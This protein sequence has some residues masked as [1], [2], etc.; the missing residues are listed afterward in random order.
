MFHC[1]FLQPLPL[2]PVPGIDPYGDHFGSFGTGSSLGRHTLNPMT[3]ST[4]YY[5][6]TSVV[7]NKSNN[8][9]YLGC[10]LHI[11]KH[12][13]SLSILWVGPQD[14]IVVGYMC[15]AEFLAT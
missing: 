7:F 2:P 5:I 12:T 15:S 14:N 13:I 10:L 8:Y 9:S 3:V 11:V 1:S 6:G 4:D